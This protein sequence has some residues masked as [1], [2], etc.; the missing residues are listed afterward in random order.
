MGQIIQAQTTWNSLPLEETYPFSNNRSFAL[1]Y[2]MA[3]V[4]CLG[5][6]NPDED[7]Y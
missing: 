6:A 2:L 3:Y 7:K 1:D 5:R 4:N